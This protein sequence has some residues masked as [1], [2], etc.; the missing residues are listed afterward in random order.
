MLELALEWRKSEESAR[1]GR[2]IGRNVSDL[3][4]THNYFLE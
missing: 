1:F 2:R 4:V 3:L